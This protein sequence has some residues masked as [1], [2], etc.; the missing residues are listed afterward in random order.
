MYEL[1]LKKGEERRILA[2]EPWVFANEVAKINGE[3][4]QGEVCK[5]FASDGRFVCLGYIN[6]LSK[7]IVRVLSYKEEEINEQFF[8]R[9]SYA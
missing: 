3:G 9:V 2:G 4:K 6:H 8:F 1:I 7:I 5:V